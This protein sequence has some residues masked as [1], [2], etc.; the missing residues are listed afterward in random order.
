MKHAFLQVTPNIFSNGRL[1]RSKA[2]D[3]EEDDERNAQYDF[4][5]GSGNRHFKTFAHNEQNGTLDRDGPFKAYRETNG[6]HK[7]GK[8]LYVAGT[9][10]NQAFSNTENLFQDLADDVNYPSFKL[11]TLRDTN[12]QK[13]F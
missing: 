1:K 4:L 6:L 3:E 8:A 5:N 10:V 12:W 2:E 9:R 11:N 7:E 13:I